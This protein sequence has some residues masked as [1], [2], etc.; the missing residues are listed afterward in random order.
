MLTINTVSATDN[1]PTLEVRQARQARQPDIA[2]LAA[3]AMTAPRQTIQAII[4]AGASD[5]TLRRMAHA[6]PGAVEALWRFDEA[7][8]H[9]R[10][11]AEEALEEAGWIIQH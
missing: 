11:D 6:A 9:F 5:E 8:R 7:P 2:A 4:K 10:I 3:L 1:A